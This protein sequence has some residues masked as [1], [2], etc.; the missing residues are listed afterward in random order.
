MA[1]GSALGLHV[2]A[3]DGIDAGLVASVL[4]EPAEQVGIQA[5]G[6]DFFWDW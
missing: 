1:A 2:G 6:Y 4:T 5:H 3:E